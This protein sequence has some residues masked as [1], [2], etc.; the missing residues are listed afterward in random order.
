[1]NIVIHIVG[2]VVVALALRQH[3]LRSQNVISVGNLFSAVWGSNILA[4]E[5]GLSGGLRLSPFALAVVYLSWWGFLLGCLWV[6]A[7]RA[8]LLSPAAMGISRVR[9]FG[10]VL[11]LCGLQ[12]VA[13][14]EEIS[15][16][17]WNPA[18][19]YDEFSSYRVR[20]DSV[21]AMSV[22]AF[23]T[24]RWASVVYVPFAIYLFRVGTLK[25]IYFVLI[26]AVAAVAT[27]PSFTR[28]PILQFLLAVGCC[29]V[30]WWR[31]SKRV[32]LI[33]LSLAAGGFLFVAV[34]MQILLDQLSPGYN[35]YRTEIWGYI[36]GPMLA[37]QTI[38]DGTFLREEG[39]YVLDGINFVL[40]KL[41]AIASYPSL[42]RPVAPALVET[43]VYTFLDAFTLDFGVAGAVAGSFLMA[44]LFSRFQVWG[45]SSGQ[46]AVMV[47]FGIFMHWTA[48]SGLNNEVVRVTIFLFGTWAFLAWLLTRS[49]FKVSRR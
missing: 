44:N 23:R 11:I 43:N 3:N 48:M 9:S 45:E 16:L 8:R 40:F 4:T 33:L 36:G 39:F 21:S 7:N 10:L 15:L 31:P 24:W 46:P 28:A 41:G 1:M 30:V 26:L 19:G 2:L 34:G 38:L 47:L 37:Y 32:Q 12:L 22:G 5:V 20:G 27:I 13:V 14:A 17:G 35:V 29:W 42:I 49:W 25:G 18:L 6:P